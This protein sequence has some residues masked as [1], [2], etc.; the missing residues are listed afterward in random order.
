MTIA[1]GPGLPA[2][3]SDRVVRQH[4]KEDRRRRG[5]NSCW[6]D[7]HVVAPT[8]RD[9]FGS[10]VTTGGRCLLENVVDGCLAVRN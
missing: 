1:I 5:G 2:R 9:D 3:T 7:R 10:D 8:L 4:D 6:V